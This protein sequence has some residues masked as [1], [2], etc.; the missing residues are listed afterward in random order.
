VGADGVRT[1]AEHSR[2]TTTSRS[3]INVLP[4][5]RAMIEGAM[6]KDN[7]DAIVNIAS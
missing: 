4:L 2:T 1:R 5:M 7:F 6:K 3:G